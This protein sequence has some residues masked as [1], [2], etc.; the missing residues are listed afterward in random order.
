MGDDWSVVEGVSSAVG[1][2]YELVTDDEVGWSNMSLERARSAR[3]NDRLNSEG[4]HSPD[5]C[6]VVDFVGR[7][8]VMSTVARQEG[9]FSSRYRR[10]EDG[11]AWRAVRRVNFDFLNILQEAVEA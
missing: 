8:G 10:K 2:I 5:V 4:A 3:R 7:Q 11:V 6:P 1:A 9:D